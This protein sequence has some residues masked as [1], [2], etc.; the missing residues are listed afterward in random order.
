MLTL[1]GWVGSVTRADARI[2]GAIGFVEAL[3]VTLAAGRVSY[4]YD[5]S[6]TV[7]AFLRRRW[8]TPFTVQRLHNNHPAFS[9]AEHLVWRLGGTP[10]WR[11]GSCR[12]CSS[13]RQSP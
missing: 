1:R 9:F 11:S 2:V 10:S 13:P 4:Y 12:P 8:L 7:G 5:E 6:V 3:V